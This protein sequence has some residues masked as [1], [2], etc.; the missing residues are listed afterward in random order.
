ME[1]DSKY[2]KL[3]QEEDQLKNIDSKLLEK[4]KFEYQELRIAIQRNSVVAWSVITIMIPISCGLLIYAIQNFVVLTPE[5][6]AGCMFASMSLLFVLNWIHDRMTY[7]DK[8]RIFRMKEI[9]GYLHMLSYSIWEDGIS[10]KAWDIKESVEK[11]YYKWQGFLPW[12]RGWHIH[13]VIWAF[14][15]IIYLIWLAILICKVGSVLSELLVARII[16]G[17]V[18]IVGVAGVIIFCTWKSK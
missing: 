8:F 13:S 2:E 17:I 9:E 11:D 18:G 3:K 4:L 5:R 7:C 16:W 6:M 10:F 15:L 1:N 12:L 14:T